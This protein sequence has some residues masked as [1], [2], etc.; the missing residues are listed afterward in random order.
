MVCAKY[1]LNTIVLKYN[2]CYLGLDDWSEV[3][4]LLEIENFTDEGEL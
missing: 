4:G 2:K 1:S 3:E